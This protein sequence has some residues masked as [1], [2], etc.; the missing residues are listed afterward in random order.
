MSRSARI[1]LCAE[2]T[3]EDIDRAIPVGLLATPDTLHQLLA[4]RDAAGIARERV[5]QTKLG[6]SEVDAGTVQVGLHVGGIDQQFHDPDRLAPL[7]AA[8]AH[9][10][11]ADLGPVGLL[12][13]RRAI[14]LRATVVR[15]RARTGDGLVAT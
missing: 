6:Q 15:I 10:Q 14:H 5:E 7:E 13:P 3:D 4:C 9:T 12:D 11:P 8:R 1:D 2:T